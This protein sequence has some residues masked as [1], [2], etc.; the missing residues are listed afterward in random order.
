VGDARQILVTLLQR[1]QHTLIER[2]GKS[3]D[4]LLGRKREQKG[5]LGDKLETLRRSR[6]LPIEHVAQS[7]ECSPDYLEKIEK[8]AVVPSVSLLLRIAQALAV[9]PAPLLTMAEGIKA[10][11][12]RTESYM[13]RTQSYSYRTLT[14]GAEDKHLRAFLVTIDPRKDHTMVEYRHEGE[15]FVYVVK[16]EVEIKVGEDVH[17]LSKGESL[18]FD[19][20]IP[21]H[22]TN[23]SSQI[24]ELV[25]VL[26][27]P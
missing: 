25:V 22:L 15:E 7:L 1:T 13:K 16:G 17:G 19:A 10:E 6:G 24:T 26:Y 18:H 27:T 11:K 8:D 23:R 14:P 9:D 3:V 4:E 20:S 5:S 21:H 2:Y 12:T